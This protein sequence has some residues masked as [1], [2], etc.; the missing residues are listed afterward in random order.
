MLEKSESCH[1]GGAEKKRVHFQGLFVLFFENVL[2]AGKSLNRQRGR[3]SGQ[4]R[5]GGR[6]E[7]LILA[8][9]SAAQPSALS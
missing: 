8:S 1:R 6:R 2:G 4:V 5:R 9:K 7:G 3:S